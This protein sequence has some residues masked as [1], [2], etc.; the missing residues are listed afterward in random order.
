MKPNP[1]K[2]KRSLG[3]AMVEFALCA[4]VFL[5]MIMAVIDLSRYVFI[6]GTMS[7]IVRTAARYGVTGETTTDS[8]G[9]ALT[10][11]QSVIVEAQNNNPVPSMI[12]VSGV[13]TSFYIQ[14]VTSAATYP[15]DAPVGEKVLFRLT[16]QFD[17]IT[18]FLHLLDGTSDPFDIVVETIY[19]IEK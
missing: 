12:A 1:I 11:S 13:S 16:Q 4:P 14:N 10:W 9:T 18:P 2:R 7:H 3:Q 15:T 5:F 17:F 6:E 19:E 8:S